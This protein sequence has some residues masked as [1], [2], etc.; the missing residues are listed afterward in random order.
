MFIEIPGGRRVGARF[1]LILVTLLGGC[2]APATDNGSAA[3]LAVADGNGSSCA[4]DRDCPS[5]L[6]CE[7]RQH[8][9]VACLQDDD[10]PPLTI[11]HE[12]ACARGCSPER[13]CGDG[14]VCQ[15][16]AGLCLEC[17]A[18]ADCHDAAR[19]RCDRVAGRCAPCL[20]V[21]V[22][23]SDNCGVGLYCSPRG[24]GFEC[25][26]GCKADGDCA[27]TDGGALRC[28]VKSHRC[29]RCLVDAECP[30][31]QICK[32]G[33]CVD[34]CSGMRACAGALSCCG[35]S[36]VDVRGDSFNCGA[37]G[38]ACAGGWTCCKSTCVNP[39]DD[40]MNCG[41]CGV[42][43]SVANGA[44]ACVGRACAIG[45]CNAGWDDCNGSVR[46]GCETNTDTNPFN[47]GG[48]GHFCTIPRAQARCDKGQCA[49]DVCL[50]FFADCNGQVQ[51]GCETNTRSDVKNC[52]DCNLV[53]G[54]AHATPACVAG[55]CAIAACDAGFADCNHWSGDGCEVPVAADL[56]NCGA[57]G[58]L[59]TAING[60][61]AC[62]KGVCQIACKPG[63]GNCDGDAANGCEVNLLGDDGNCG[64]CGNACAAAHGKSAC[65]AGACQ[66]SS[67]DFGWADC[68]RNPADGCEK[69]L[70]S[71]TAN[72][73]VCGLACSGNHIANPTCSIGLCSGTCNQGFADCNNNKQVDGCESDTTGDAGNCGG[74]GMACGAVAN[75]APAC[76]NS[77]CAIGSCNA[78][79]ANCDGNVNNGCEANLN[80]DASHCGNCQ[81][82]CN[83]GGKCL[84]GVC[85]YAPVLIGSYRVGD[86][87]GYGH[88]PCYTCQE[89]C[90]VVFGG[91]ANQYSC[92]ID[93]NNITHTGHLS[94]W[95]SDAYCNNGAAENYKVNTFY[96]CGGGDCSFSAY[97]K[98]HCPNSVNYCFR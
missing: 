44:P 74:C 72:C 45:G 29:A 78:G 59:C 91:A 23:G 66:I 41:G 98:D 14:G 85:N 18:D 7:V 25:A 2:P 38:N 53:C 21:E 61:A 42:V 31:G 89:A 37:C 76:V 32:E 69:N 83:Q 34:G 90:A 16:D 71:D 33:A 64:A 35:T 28:D 96:D 70:L 55:A 26:P 40:L 77:A 57:C 22:G 56:K 15:A 46:D 20:P 12:N 6:R 94:G 8:A 75:G 27:G 86:G 92:S 65:A 67:C 93:P 81:T 36:C 95:G 5:S 80:T 43:C 82:A 68:N 51:D 9:C 60:T 3:D 11:C 79:Y 30:D 87:P 84:N 24:A 58:N 1:A 54:S 19:P 48:C 39:T 97:I 10:C 50:G 52:G 47:C 4:S 13:G 63:F 49:I 17:G 62:V 73:G 88:V